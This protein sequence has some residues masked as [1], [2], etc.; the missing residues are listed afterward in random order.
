[1][2]R[3]SVSTLYTLQ[4]KDETDK[5]ADKFLVNSDSKEIFDILFNISFNNIDKY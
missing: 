4:Y 5:T 1:M 2:I 3:I